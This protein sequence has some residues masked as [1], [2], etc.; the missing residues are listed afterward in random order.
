MR[1]WFSP[2]ISCLNKAASIPY[3]IKQ[4][5]RDDLFHI[6]KGTYNKRIVVIVG[7]SHRV[8]SGWLVRLLRDAAHLQM[9][10]RKTPKEYLRFG[11]IVLTPDSY[12]FLSHLSGQ[13][14]YKSHSLPP[15]SSQKTS[16]ISFVTIF[17]DPRD[18]LTSA[19]YYLAHLE[20]S[21][22]GLGP[23]FRSLNIAERILWLIDRSEYL[24][25]LELWYRTPVAIKIR[26][27]DLLSNTTDV[28]HDTVT[29]LGIPVTPKEVSGVVMHHSFEA[30]TGRRPGQ[31]KNVQSSRKGISGDWRNHFN[32]TCIT[33]FKTSREGR[34]NKLLFEMKYETRHDWGASE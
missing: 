30:E 16:N 17:R 26:Y 9:G 14:I 15:I 22:G 21:R 27:E 12:Q 3:R 10:M 29:H 25:E 11:T 1:L 32:Q 18:V 6:Q 23:D 31:G 19:I 34:W 5:V 4:N 33:A 8:G 7:S 24:E 20:E 28:L 13:T 2:L